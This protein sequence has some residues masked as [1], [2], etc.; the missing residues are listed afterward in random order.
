MLYQGNYYTCDKCEKQI[1]IG[2]ALE[3]DGETYC[4]NCLDA[5]PQEYIINET[6]PKAKLPETISSFTKEMKNQKEKSDKEVF[7]ESSSIK[8]G[9]YISGLVAATK[10]YDNLENNE[11][12]GHLFAKTLLEIFNE[13]SDILEK[14]GVTIDNL[15]RKDRLSELL[16][17]EMLRLLKDNVS[18]YEDIRLNYNST[19]F[20]FEGIEINDEVAMGNYLGNFVDLFSSVDFDELDFTGTSFDTLTINELF[21]TYF[22]ID[23]DKKDPHKELERVIQSHKAREE[24]HNLERKAEIEKQKRI[25]ELE[26]KRETARSRIARRFYRRDNKEIK[27][28]HSNKDIAPPSINFDIEIIKKEVNEKVI[29]QEEAKNQLIMEFYKLYT[30]GAPRNNIFLVGPS[31][32]GKTYLVRTL[33]KVLSELYKKQ[34]YQDVPED[35]I[36]KRS[37][38]VLE[39]EGGNPKSVKEKIT[40]E[41]V[42]E[43]KIMELPFLEVDIQQFTATGYK[44]RDVSTMFD[45]LIRRYCIDE[46]TNQINLENISG[47]VIFLDELDKITTNAG[48][49]GD[50][51]KLQH[52]LL[53]IIEGD[54]IPVDVP[55]GD[56][57][58]SAVLDTSSFIFIGAGACVGLEEIRDESGIGF[59][60]KNENKK[61]RPYTA[62]DLIEF[63]FIPE[64]LGRFP[65]IAELEQLSRE[66]WKNYIQYN[67]N[68]PL[69]EADEIML[70]FNQNRK[71][72]KQT[73][74]SFYYNDEI[75]EE[76]VKE[77]MEDDSLG[78][79]G[80]KSKVMQQFNEQLNEMIEKDQNGDIKE[81]GKSNVLHFEYNR[82]E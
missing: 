7:R 23:I 44:G 17:D 54:K 77:L 58:Y 57:K 33:V 39:T 62:K 67:E 47:A 28:S 68:S 19:I 65:I 82:Y 35:E 9:V 42:G 63:G 51:R 75:I 2:E 45:D 61:S 10:L 5:L 78:V 32:T 13:Y 36:N 72:Y 24:I 55:V 66:E 41:L 53:K 73:R 30:L 37:M 74:I 12:V 31:G 6:Y 22:K 21:E 15:L 40:K 64:L 26:K 81:D 70:R 34:Q 16:R 60:Q 14:N 38:E 49:D 20:D 3:L 1:P 50:P 69:L 27:I 18:G 52:N 43:R 4:K 76:L 25:K 46:E 59:S 29:S 80:L 8:G 48:G 11:P 79:R 71:E 56:K